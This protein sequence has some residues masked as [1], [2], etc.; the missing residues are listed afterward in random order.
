MKK[1]TLGTK[2]SVIDEAIFGIVKEVSKN[3]IVIISKE[4]FELVFQENELVIEEGLSTMKLTEGLSKEIFLEK[5][6]RPKKKVIS[7][8]KKGTIPPME[9][10]L[11]I[12]QLAKNHKQLSAYQI[13]NLQ[14]DTAKYKLEFAIKNKIQR[15]IFIHGVGEGVLR[16]ELEFLI[17]KYDALKMTDADYQKYGR[18]AIEVYIPQ[19]AMQN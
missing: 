12:E 2:V 18:G 3:G 19:V 11:H 10:D 15:L 6:I 5:E 7:K 9:V 8:T 4:G 16:A 17:K 1:I 14:M 13:L